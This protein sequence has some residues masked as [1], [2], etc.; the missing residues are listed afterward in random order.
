MKPLTDEQDRVLS[1]IIQQQRTS[2]SPPTIREIC[3][4]MGYKSINN[5]R[6]HLR[7][8][9][10]KGYIRLVKGKARGIELLIDVERETGENEIKVPLIG[11]VAAGAPITAEENVQGHVTLDRS[12]FK[13]KDLFT[14][15]IKGDS[16]KGIGVL[17][18]DI[19]IVRQQNAARDGEIIVAIIEG[20][21]TLKRY[22]KKN[23]HVILRAENPEYKDIIVPS[24]RGVWIVGKMVG[25][26]RKC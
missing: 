10:Q 7:L 15:R 3:F 11:T 23:N 19:V 24:D 18:G 5:A 4:A 13:G 16:M 2:G 1:F 9:E 22:I 25:I 8:I 20:D 14:L 21:A 26:I 17:D 6:Q 12:L